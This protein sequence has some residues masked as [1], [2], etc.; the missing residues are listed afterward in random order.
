MHRKPIYVHKVHILCYLS[1][2]YIYISAINLFE[3][4]GVIALNWEMSSKH[5]VRMLVSHEHRSLSNKYNTISSYLIDAMGPEM[6]LYMAHC[7][8][9]INY[10]DW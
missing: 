2:I 6:F 1:K 9:W 4:H 8:I 10:S 3:T 7:K 5:G